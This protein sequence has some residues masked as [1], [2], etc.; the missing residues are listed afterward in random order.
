MTV[1]GRLCHEINWF[2]NV[3]DSHRNELIFD[4][5]FIQSAKSS[6]RTGIFDPSSVNADSLC[7]TDSQGKVPN[8]S[9]V[10]FPQ[11]QTHSDPFGRGRHFSTCEENATLD[12][13]ELTSPHYIR[14][15]VNDELISPHAGFLIPFS[16]VF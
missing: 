14:T 11:I 12:K 3:N 8:E 16:W 13:W 2:S 7:E 15:F 9:A 1:G 6:F 5:G 10:Q 4:R